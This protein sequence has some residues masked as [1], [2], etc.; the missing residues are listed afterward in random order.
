MRAHLLAGL[1]LISSA[2]AGASHPFSFDDMARLRRLG[3]FDVSRD[4]KW[5][6]YAVTRADVDENKTTSALWL[7]PTDRSAPPRQL[8]TGVKKDKEPRFSPD[9]KRVAFVSDR[10]G[11]P[12][13]YLIDLAGG[14][15]Q[16][17]TSFVE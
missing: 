8:T 14:E 13:V 15:P 12:Q 2:A 3:D 5:V 10:D 11:A 17:L 7:L 9:G 4:G 6:V 1:L 16:K